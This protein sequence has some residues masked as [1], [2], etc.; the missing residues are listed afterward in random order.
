[1]LLVLGLLLTCLDFAV[2]CPAS[3]WLFEVAVVLPVQHRYGFHAEWPWVA[4][5][6]HLVIDHVVPGGR[7][8]RAGIKQG[9]AFSPARCGW[10]ALGGGW[11]A[12]LGNTTGPADVV[13]ETT[14]GHLETETTFHVP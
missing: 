1:M 9:Y 10:F 11:Y 2:N 5:N 13:L 4:S 6:A 3:T 8:Q 7:F 12:L 14:P